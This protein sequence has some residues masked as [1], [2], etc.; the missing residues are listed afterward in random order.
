MDDAFDQ[1]SYCFNVEIDP[2]TFNEA[3]KSQDVAFWEEAIN[4]EMDFIMGN[5]TWVLADLPPVCTPMD[6]S[7]KLMANN[8][9]AVSQ[10][11][12]SRMISRLMCVMTCTRPDIAFVV[13]KLS[14]YTSNPSTQHW[15][16]IQNV[17]KYLKKTMDD[18][19][20]S[21]KQNCI[22]GSIM[23]SEFVPLATAGKEAEWLRNLILKIPLRSKPI[24]P[25]FIRFD[26]AA[27]LAKAYNQM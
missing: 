5:N 1:H 15:Q 26:S 22:I 16:A 13:G 21:K 12:Y 3:M 7:E 24:A 19:L 6:T 8:G 11:E 2:K 27:T 14:R 20:A 10:L 25:I 17:L 9:Q 18:S 4:D 23:K